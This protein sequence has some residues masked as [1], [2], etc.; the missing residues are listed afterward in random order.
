MVAEYKA[1]VEKLEAEVA[2]LKA[3]TWEQE[4][5]AVVAWLRLESSYQNRPWVVI[6]ADIERG[7]HWPEKETP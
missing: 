4:R 6:T 5:A 2:Q 7:E 3:H 1:V